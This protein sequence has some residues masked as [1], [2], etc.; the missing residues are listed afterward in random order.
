[1]NHLIAHESQFVLTREHAQS[2]AILKEHMCKIWGTYKEVKQPETV[3]IGTTLATLDM[4][5]NVENLCIS[6]HDMSRHEDYRQIET[7]TKDYIIDARRE[8]LF[9]SDLGNDA[10]ID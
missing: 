7:V 2:F 4:I 3:A 6:F 1:M 5:S 9:L 10:K 8:C